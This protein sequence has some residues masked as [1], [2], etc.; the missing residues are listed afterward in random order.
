MPTSKT[1][2]S[3]WADIKASI[4]GNDQD[5][6]EGKLGRAILLLSIPMVL[7]MAME[8]VFAIVD[9]FFVSRLGADAVATVGITES[10]ITI[11]YAIGIGLSMGTTAMVA[12]RIGE[13]DKIGASKSAVQAIIVGFLV[14][15]PI[16]L[17][18]IF[19]AKDLLRLMGAEPVIVETMYAY[20]SIMIGGNAVIM[21]L[22]VI[23]AIFR[24]AGDAAISMRVLWLAN[25]LNIILDPILI[26]G[27]GFIPAFGV[28]GAAIATVIGRGI[29]VLY[30]LYL[31]S[32]N[33]TRVTIIKE[34]L[35]VQWDIMKRLIRLSLGGIGQFIIATSSWIG[36]VR[37]L[38]EFGSITVAGYTIAIRIFIFS[39]LPSWGMSN[40]AATLVGQNLGANKPERA[41]KSV[42]TT[43]GVNMVFLALVGITFYIFAE[44]LIALFSTDPEI[45][46]IGAQC[47]R[48]ISYGYLAYAFGMIII[49][50]FNGAGD[51]TTPTIINFIC[52]WLIEIPLAYLLALEFGFKQDGVFYA[53]VVAETL[54]GVIG[55]L[56]FR[57]GNWKK[58]NV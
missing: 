4:A 42:W 11:V 48:I 7:E 28:K 47:L 26:F 38:A 14:S 13:K 58:V 40:A 9:I 21:L 37:I 39:I 25:G 10:L 52:F 31:L 30:Q 45:I 54:L 33:Q 22:F 50:A 44:W 18:G 8:S 29:G 23:N 1:E 12:R 53:I 15:L 43:A 46:R 35:V 57:K 17:I 16:S 51:T 36:L 34:T 20:T 32:K 27:I 2:P 5:F 19:Y 55:F 3:L 6:T 24:G 49:Q 56:I 41:E